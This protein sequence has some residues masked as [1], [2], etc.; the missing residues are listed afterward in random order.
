MT[1]LTAAQIESSAPDAWT[2][3]STA[4]TY[5]SEAQVST[6]LTS[7]GKTVYSGRDEDQKREDMIIVTE[8]VEDEIRELFGGSDVQ[9]NQGLLFPSRGAYDS[10]GLL[11]DHDTAPSGLTDGIALL[12]EEQASGTFMDRDD[13]SSGIKRE[14]LTLVETEFFESVDQASMSYQHPGPWRRISEAIPRVRL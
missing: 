2:G 14:K 1:A 11:I 8:R 3:K 4:L 7:R 10:R 12:C 6:F 9:A 13:G 5:E